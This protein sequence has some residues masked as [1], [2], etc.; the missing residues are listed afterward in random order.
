MS[1]SFSGCEQHEHEE[2]RFFC[3]DCKLL[4]CDDCIT[5]PHKS[6]KFMKLK[7]FG[8]KCRNS[9]L[10]AITEAEDSK[11]PHIKESISKASD[12]QTILN[13]SVSEQVQIIRTK[14]QMINDTF[15][16]L[17][18][19]LIEN[20]NSEEKI[21]DNE[22][23]RFIKT[24]E[25][26]IVDIQTILETCKTKS[27]DIPDTDIAK[28]HVTLK[29]LLEH[30][31]YT[32]TIPNLQVPVYQF[33]EEFATK[34]KLRHIMG[35]TEAGIYEML[36]PIKS[37][38]TASVKSEDSE[39]MAPQNEEFEEKEEEHISYVNA[40]KWNKEEL[41]LVVSFTSGKDI[42]WIVPQELEL[43]A[44]LIARDVNEIDCR[45]AKITLKTLKNLDQVPITASVNTKNSLVIGFSNKKSLKQLNCSTSAVTRKTSFSL[46]SSINI[47]ELGLCC[48][49]K[50]ATS[51]D[52]LMICLFDKSAGERGRYVV[53]RH[54][55]G[56]SVAR[57]LSLYPDKV[58]ITNPVQ[59]S[60]NKDG[61]LCIVCRPE[62]ESWVLVVDKNGNQRFRF[63]SVSYP[64]ESED[65]DI[66]GAG[67]LNRS[68]VTITSRSK[69]EQYLVNIDGQCIQKD[70]LGNNPICCTVSGQDN[71][72][73][74]FDG[75]EIYIFKYTE[76]HV[77]S[78]IEPKTH[79]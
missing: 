25:K 59:I 24:Q 19:E 39:I 78:S 40:I 53:R 52:E 75:G 46:S 33:N 58:E 6:H 69:R 34:S 35:Y 5:G 45:G 14:R 36:Q 60:E 79:M 12:V 61:L 68:L 16:E 7:E 65:Y 55:S 77:Y 63:P 50:S 72:W 29:K 9:L 22:Y 42:V 57:E 41:Q 76:D 66:V 15:D 3:Q 47:G 54:T 4:V 56:K 38:E 23:K 62:K 32:D 21:A 73:V 48:I 13:T 17:Q 43:C 37:Q 30:D 64:S 1:V 74:G 10:K 67:F 28:Y 49:C 2:V 31:P 27:N 26:R 51:G 11:I 70:T 44:W 8:T 18:N 71:V 20:L